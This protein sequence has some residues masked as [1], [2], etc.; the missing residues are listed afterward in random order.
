MQHIHCLSTYLP[1]YPPTYLTTYLLCCAYQ[2]R[3]PE[4]YMGGEVYVCVCTSGYSVYSK[5]FQFLYFFLHGKKGYE[6]L[7]LL[8]FCTA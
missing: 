1:I 3:S 5:S 6:K 8:D 2:K 7:H 4:L